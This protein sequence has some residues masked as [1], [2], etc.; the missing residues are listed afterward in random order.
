MFLYRLRCYALASIVGLAL[1]GLAAASMT[2]SFIY[3]SFDRDNLCS[4]ESANCFETEPGVVQGGNGSTE[5][6]VS[7]IVGEPERV[8]A[9]D[10]W[11]ETPPPGT[12]VSLERWE[13]DEIAFVYV[14]DNGSRY[15]TNGAPDRET[16]LF[17]AVILALLAVAAPVQIVRAAS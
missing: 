5:M 13:G 2:G 12:H 17:V 14:P 11:N 4:G 9:Y 7:P 3:V 8:H 1:L 16:P 10:G 6:E 15:K